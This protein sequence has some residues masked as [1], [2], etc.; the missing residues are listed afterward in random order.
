[1]G[2]FDEYRQRNSSG[3]S[4]DSNEDAYSYMKQNRTSSIL[5]FV[6]IIAA[7]FVYTMVG[8]NASC[9]GE[10]T[11]GRVKLINDNYQLLNEWFTA[12]SDYT[13]TAVVDAMINFYESTGIQPYVLLVSETDSKTVEELDAIAEDYYRNE[14]FGDIPVDEEHMVVAFQGSTGNA[15]IYAGTAAQS[16]MDEA[17]IGEFRTILSACYNKYEGTKILQQT[18][19]QATSKIMGRS[20]LAI[21]IIIALAIICVLYFIY[22]YT[23]VS[24]RRQKEM[25][26][27]GGSNQ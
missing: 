24:K 26:N 11:T 17:A 20:K 1:M 25:E 10:T 27:N 7:Y 4:S 14:L 21:Y 19:K 22:N 2:L 5:V 8:N 9:A 15:G 3:S 16:V 12:E 18:F 23:K 13:D 6:I